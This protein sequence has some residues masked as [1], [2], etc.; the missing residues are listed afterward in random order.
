[1][2][3]LFSLW[4]TRSEAAMTVLSGHVVVCIFGDVS[5]ALIGL[6]NL[7]MPL[8]ASNF[9]YH[10]LK[11]IVFVGSIEYLKREWETLHNF[12]K[13]SI[14]PVSPGSHYQCFFLLFIHK[15]EIPDEYNVVALI[16][17]LLLHLVMGLRTQPFPYTLSRNIQTLRDLIKRNLQPSSVTHHGV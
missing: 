9:H 6:R 11:H 12:P 5:S 16:M 17:P 14:L 15:R 7:V 1:M 8:R 4:Q 13:V 2:L 3:V 10:E